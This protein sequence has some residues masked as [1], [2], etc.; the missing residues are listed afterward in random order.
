ML[1]LILASF[2]PKER[3]DFYLLLLDHI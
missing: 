3:I 1:Q 2:F